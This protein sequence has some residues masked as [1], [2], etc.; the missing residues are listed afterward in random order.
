MP[1]M[2]DWQRSREMSLFKVNVHHGRGHLPRLLCIALERV[3]IPMVDFF[4]NWKGHQA[5]VHQVT[6]G[7]CI[8]RGKC[9]DVAVQWLLVPL[10]LVYLSRGGPDFVN[11]EEQQPSS[12]HKGHKTKLAG[13]WFGTFFIFPYIENNHPS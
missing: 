12:L 1:G 13:W 5:C 10:L 11:H 3:A 2:Q 6:F 7:L 8:P 4:S 9:K